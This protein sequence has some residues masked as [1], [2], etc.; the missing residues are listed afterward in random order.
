MVFYYVYFEVRV[1]R[2]LLAYAH[3][4][5]IPIVDSHL[6]EKFTLVPGAYLY[7]VYPGI[8]LYHQDGGWVYLLYRVIVCLEGDPWLMSWIRKKYII[9]WRY[10]VDLWMCQT[11][12]GVR[13]NTISFRRKTLA[14]YGACFRIGTWQEAMNETV[15]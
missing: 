3:D 12:A 2:G 5:W 15:Y 10:V 4:S 6:H 13:K 7:G 14:G 8:I 9:V 1:Y 11:G